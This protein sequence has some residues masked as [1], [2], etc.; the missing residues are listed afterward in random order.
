MGTHLGEGAPLKEMV[1]LQGASIHKQR[2][3]QMWHLKQIGKGT[4]SAA[5][6]SAQSPN[7][8]TQRA[9]EWRSSDNAPCRVVSSGFTSLSKL[10]GLSQAGIMST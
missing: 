1:P 5:V 2:K 4:D 7:R 6:Y 8:D 3:C 9:L 10:L